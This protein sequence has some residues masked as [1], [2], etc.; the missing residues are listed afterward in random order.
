MTKLSYITSCYNSELFLNGLIKDLLTQSEGDFELIV[1]DSASTDGSVKIVKEWMER[2]D[3]IKLIEQPE[4][5]PY[6]VS[7]LTGWLQASGDIVGN[8]NS[9]DRSYAWRGTQVLMH[10]D[11]AREL[12]GMLK[13]DPK[14]FYY[15]GYETRVDGVVTAK[16]HPPPYTEGDLQRFFRCGIHVHWDNSLRDRVDWEMM[17]NAGNEYRSAFDYWLVLYFTSLGATG[18]SIPSCFSI[19]NQRADS[20]EQSDKELSSFEGMRAIRTFYP[21]GPVDHDLETKTRVD[22]PEYYK[23]FKDFLAKFGE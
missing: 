1:V 19:Y 4:R 23:R 5:T 11:Q 12:D 20:L 8:A 22:S 15:G 21:G 10:R 14:H 9:D 2:D 17:M 18:V 7:W 3:R 16:G 6:G 13:Q